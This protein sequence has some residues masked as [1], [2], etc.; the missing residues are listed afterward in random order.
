ML[1]FGFVFL[2]I[3]SL[4]TGEG[5]PN[6]S[7]FTTVT[8]LVILGTGAL[9]IAS[10]FFT[11]YGFAYVEAALASNIVSL[12]SFFAVIFGFLFYKEIPT[13]QVFIG[14]LLIIASVIFLNK[15]EEKK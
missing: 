6:I 2:F 13:L 1:L 10:L 8:D 3:L 4:L 14:G 15:E 12:E 9:N 7:Q 5:I 11:N